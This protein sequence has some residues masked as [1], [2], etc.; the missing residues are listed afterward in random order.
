MSKKKLL[1]AII[2]L[3]LVI[4]MVL[5]GTLAVSTA[6]SASESSLSVDTPTPDTVNMPVDVKTGD[7]AVADAKAAADQTP[8]TSQD[9]ASSGETGAEGETEQKECNCGL[10]DGTHLN[11][12]PLYQNTTETTPTEPETKPGESET[13][14]TEGETGST[15]TGE[16]GGETKDPENPET[17][18]EPEKKCD[19]GRT[20]GTHAETCPLYEKPAEPE[21]TCTCGSLDG[22]HAADCP[23]YTAPA[24]TCTCGSTDG[25]HA[26]TCPLYVA[27]QPKDYTD[28]FNQFMATT[29]IEEFDALY[30][31]LTEEDRTG[32]EEWLNNTGN[33]TALNEHAMAILPEE[34]LPETVVFTDAGPFLPAVSVASTYS[35]RRA[36]RAANSEEKDDGI[37][38]NK[39]AYIDENG[40]YKITL[41]SYTTGTVTTDTKTVPVDIVLVL[42]Q[43]TS[44]SF[45]FTDEEIYDYEG[46]DTRSRQYAMKK[47]VNGFIDEVNKQYSETADHR[48][49]IVK[50]GADANTVR[51]WTEVNT[52]G[53]NLLKNAVMGL[54][55]G[56]GVGTQT[57]KGMKQANELI[58]TNYSYSGINRD[59]QKVVILFTDGTPGD[60]GFT[61]TVATEAIKYAHNIKQSGATI[62]TIGIFTGANVDQLF[63]EKQCNYYNYGFGNYGYNESPTVCNGGLNEWWG[64]KGHNGKSWNQY[65]NTDWIQIPAANRFLNYV[66]SNFKD[67]SAI[68]LTLTT[69]KNSIGS[70][71]DEYFTVT[72]N[73]GR[74]ASNYY[75][76]AN[77]AESLNSIF[78][79]ISQNISTPTIELGEETVV[80]DVISDYFEL[81]ANTTDIKVYTADATSI[82]LKTPDAGNAWKEKVLSSLQPTVDGKTISVSGFNYTDNFVAENGR[83]D[84]N[85]FFGRKLILEFTV[86]AIDGFL[87]GNDVPTNEGAGIYKDGTKLKDFPVPT[88]NIEI[89]DITVTAEDKNVYLLSE[90]TA[91]QLQKGVKV[92]YG[93]D[94][95]YEIKLDPNETNFGLDEKVNKYVDI[96]VKVK[97][98]DGTEVTESL[99]NLTD[100]TTNTLEVTISPNSDGNTNKFEVKKAKTGTSNS[101]NI[102]VYKPELTFKD[103]TAYYGD[104]IGALNNET[105]LVSMPWVH[106]DATTGDETLSTTVTM[107]GSAPTLV[108]SYTYETTKLDETTHQIK[109]KTGDIPV[110]VTVKIGS[111]DVTRYVTFKHQNCTSACSWTAPEKPGDPAFLI[112]VKT[113]QLTIK[114]QGGTSGES[115][116]F[117]VYKDGSTGVYTQVSVWGTGNSETIYELPV[118][119]YTVKEDQGWSWRWSAAESN[120]ATLSSEAPS[121]TVE[122]QNT[123]N[124]KN[125]WLNGFS[126]IVQNIFGKTN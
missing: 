81:P 13:G 74:T 122:Y 47:A 86:K 37:V 107:T 111:E 30:Q 16:S 39:T 79:K 77:S 62:Y 80:Q 58:N 109:T 97:K 92:T 121:A 84:N 88:V 124:G 17:P 91:A 50:F 19:C 29:T 112:H 71:R 27:P 20:D 51:G 57:Q 103:S 3:T 125:K 12:C 102:Y 87:G 60:K 54:K 15:E 114:K 101:A 85:D 6:Q 23:L 28:L 49:A 113:C 117:N 56:Y 24:L 33:V 104:T 11:T 106:K 98:A 35:A 82:A 25:T 90:V 100:D 43:S 55:I 31:S 36:A 34:V 67:A 105:N 95:K 72:S 64:K 22:T 89:P 120:S 14:T 52:S 99:D 26:E 7:A 123:S 115:Y 70:L 53:M 10:T 40:N 38:L 8:S 118:G 18:A 93:P 45:T 66:S 42:D 21:K 41:E 61:P 94:G 116:V 119:N 126:T 83:G 76:T 44:M 68:G 75:L 110:K 69:S 96:T 9:G 32:F 46:E 63:G 5:P 108:K 1:A 2:S 78:Q 4:A 73:F 48:I 65:A 59:R